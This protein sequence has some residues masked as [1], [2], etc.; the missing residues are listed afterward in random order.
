MGVELTTLMFM[1]LGWL[2]ILFGAGRIMTHFQPT[3][4]LMILGQ[5]RRNNR[6]NQCTTR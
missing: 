2:I 5:V 6:R 3:F 1:Y 4:G